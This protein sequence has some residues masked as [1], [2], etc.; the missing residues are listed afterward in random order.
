[1][2]V[3]T[4]LPRPIEAGGYEEADGLRLLILVSVTCVLVAAFRNPAEIALAHV[5]R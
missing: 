1:M 3:V 5:N 4:P 2:H